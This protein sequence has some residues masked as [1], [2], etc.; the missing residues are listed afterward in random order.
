MDISKITDT[1]YVSS[2]LQPEHIGEL[3]TRN[4][5]LVI[6]MI[7]GQPPPDFS[8]QTCH[9]LWL[10][11]CDSILIPIPMKEL[12]LGVQAA[13]PVIK[14]GQRVLV[15]CAK[16]RHR[17]NAMVAAILVATGYTADE[18]IQLLRSQRDVANPQAWHISR[19]ISKF[20]KLLKNKSNHIAD[21]VEEI[22]AEIATTLIANILFHISNIKTI[23]SSK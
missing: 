1:L 12:I 20:E 22:Y 16:G 6:S 17:S 4:I 8:N 23:K 2:K 15:Y 10:Q 11:T 21:F 9:S 14:N 5:Q 18:A 13:L 7:V 3:S 19:R